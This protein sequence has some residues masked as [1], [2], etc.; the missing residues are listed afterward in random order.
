MT[1]EA[2]R[3]VRPLDAP[4][5][6]GLQP[7]Y[8]SSWAMIVGIN[9]YQQMRHLNYAVRDAE[10]VAELLKKQFDFKDEKIFLCLNEDARKDNLL[11]IL[12]KLADETQ[13]DDR[14]LIFFAG[15]GVTHTYPN[16]DKVG[17]LVP[18]DAEDGDRL[19]YIEMKTFIEEG[20]HTS[21]KH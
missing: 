15:H 13:P 10:G 4:Q 20:N 11:R 21:A 14:V 7:T 16:G 18:F 3:N 6:S 12:N 9:D 17:Y 19:S 2:T 1:D 5:L 8:D